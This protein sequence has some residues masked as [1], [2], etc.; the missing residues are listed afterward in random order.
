M[1]NYLSLLL[2]DKYKVVELSSTVLRFRKSVLK[3]TLSRVYR[4]YLSSIDIIIKVIK[5]SRIDE[6]YKENSSIGVS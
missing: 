1:G 5:I 6:F 3:F 2:E 4:L